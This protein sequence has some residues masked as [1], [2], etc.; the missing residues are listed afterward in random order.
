MLSYIYKR[1]YSFL[2]TKRLRPRP[3]TGAL[4]SRSGHSLP[5]STTPFTGSCEDQMWMQSTEILQTLKTYITW[6]VSLFFLLTALWGIK[7][8][9]PISQ[10]RKLTT[11]RQRKKK[12][13]ELGEFYIWNGHK[14]AEWLSGLDFFS[15]MRELGEMLLKGFLRL[16]VLWSATWPW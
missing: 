15:K 2:S 11:G 16:M 6:W 1:V 12:N 14:L 10:L 8:Q 4:L 7:I 9:I 3:L 5:L 13:T